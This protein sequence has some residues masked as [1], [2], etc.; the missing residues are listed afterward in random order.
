MS[1][2]NFL[3][4]ILVISAV[5]GMY[6]IAHKRKIGFVIFLLVEFSMGYIGLVTKNYGLTVAAVIYLCMNCY[7]WF[8]WREGERDVDRR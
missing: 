7:S 1:F 2:L 3:N 4:C 8:K 6:C 5:V